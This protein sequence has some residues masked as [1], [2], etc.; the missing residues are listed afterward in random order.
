MQMS[1]KWNQVTCGWLVSIVTDRIVF[2]SWD[3]EIDASAVN[4]GC[5]WAFKVGFWAAWWKPQM[6]TTVC[7]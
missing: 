6:H 4:F 7:R 3:W 1:A 2:L 5:P